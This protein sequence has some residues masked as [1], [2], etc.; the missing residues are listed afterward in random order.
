SIL[1]EKTQADGKGSPR[2]SVVRYEGPDHRPR[3]LVVVR[4]RGEKCASGWGA[5]RKAAE[6]NA[7]K[8]ALNKRYRG[9]AKKARRATS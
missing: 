1:Q 9:W 3:C 6:Q 8:A 7:A 5:S 2:Y 4:I